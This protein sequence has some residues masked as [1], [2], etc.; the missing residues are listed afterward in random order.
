MKNPNDIQHSIRKLRVKTRAQ[1]DKRILADAS[2]ALAQSS[3]NRP[4]HERPQLWIR[5]I[6]MKNAWT[7]FATAAAVIMAVGVL[8]VAF[9][10]KSATPAYAL[11]QTIQAN[12][13][14]RSIHVKKFTSGVEEPD[15]I[16]AE[17]DDTGELLR[18]RVNQP[19]TA[20]GPKAIVW[21]ENKAKIWQEAKNMYAI[22][23]D[24]SV[25][26]QVRQDLEVMDPKLAVQNLHQL[27]TEG[28][29]KN[30]NSRTFPKGPTHQGNGYLSRE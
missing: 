24:K 5:R 26:E 25:S 10:S 17:F 6:I 29:A 11:E 18:C 12:H 19:Q 9:L 14:V 16:W 3:K 1:L 30:R 23:K 21:Q 15:E 4:T 2:A 27:K 22:I 28:K 7:K 8:W 13:S 20:D